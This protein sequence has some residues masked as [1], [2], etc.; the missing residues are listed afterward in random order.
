[1]LLDEPR[2]AEPGTPFTDFVRHPEL[3]DL[4]VRARGGRAAIDA[5]GRVWTP[6]SRLLHARAASLGTEPAAPGLLVLRAFTEMES[7]RRMRREFVAN[8]SHE[9][10]T[11]LTTI[12]G[13]AE[14]LLDGALDDVEHRSQF[15]EAIHRG[16][17]RLE[18]MVGE[19]LSLSEL[20]RTG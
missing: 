11:P 10:R 7:V 6:R 17:S 9:L 1:Q 5:D 8:V 13:Y 3:H 2:P 4:V 16:A 14:A 15:V 12:G 20:E 19:L 18:Q